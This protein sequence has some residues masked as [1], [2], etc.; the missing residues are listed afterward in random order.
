MTSRRTT[1]MCRLAARTSR[2]PTAISFL[3]FFCRPLRPRE[4]F[5]KPAAPRQPHNSAFEH[6]GSGVLR[7][8][9]PGSSAGCGGEQRLF[10]FFFVSFFELSKRSHARTHLVFDLF[11][12]VDCRRGRRGFIFTED[13]SGSNY[14]MLQ[15][16]IQVEL[17]SC[18]IELLERLLK[19]R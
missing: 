17:P 10:G 8:G 12:P 5:A 2:T 18:K 16:R 14:R 11:T 7:G 19:S 3:V 9:H 13:E 6:D 4:Q 15:G 1:S